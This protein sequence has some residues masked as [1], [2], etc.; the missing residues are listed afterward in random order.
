MIL[1][2]LSSHDKPE[3]ER[4]LKPK[5][6]LEYRV[7]LTTIG[8]QIGRYDYTMRG[9]VGPDQGT[10]EFNVSFSLEKMKGEIA[11]SPTSAERFGA[12]QATLGPTGFAKNLSFMGTAL[13]FSMPLVSF[14]LPDESGAEVEFSSPTYDGGITLVGKAWPKGSRIESQAHFLLRGEDPDQSA[15]RR[16]RVTAEFD[17]AGVLLRSEGKYTAPDGTVTFKLTKK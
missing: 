3:I 1:P 17:K 12:I 2:L 15:Y 16:L 10:K 5:A 13:S 11:G 8:T 6:V 9:V 7:E 14:Y 4:H